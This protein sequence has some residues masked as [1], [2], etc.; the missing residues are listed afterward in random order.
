MPLISKKSELDFFERG[1][2]H[3]AN[4]RPSEYQM[5]LNSGMLYDDGAGEGNRTP[6]T[7]LGSRCSTIELHPQYS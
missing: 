4:K 3:V 7:G 5:V 2:K 1:V 6:V